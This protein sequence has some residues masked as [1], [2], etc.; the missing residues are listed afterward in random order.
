VAHGLGCAADAAAAA[1]GGCRWRRGGGG[2]RDSMRI[3]I[4]HSYVKYTLEMTWV[5]ARSNFFQAARRP[6]WV[7][8]QRLSSVP[9]FGARTQQSARARGG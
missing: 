9:G 1:A 7:M 3:E 5:L 8:T 2:E 6:K 4:S